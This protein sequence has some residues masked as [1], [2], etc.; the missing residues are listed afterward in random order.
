MVWAQYSFFEALDPL[1]TTRNPAQKPST[2]S[3]CVVSLTATAPKPRCSPSL[4][5]G[6]AESCNTEGS[7]HGCA[8]LSAYVEAC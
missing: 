6:S 3:Y 1:G 4:A 5:T 8:S 7:R 2:S